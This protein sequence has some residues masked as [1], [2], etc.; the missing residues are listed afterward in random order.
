MIN[1]SDNEQLKGQL[2]HSLHFVICA[3]CIALSEQKQ[4][5]LVGLLDNLVE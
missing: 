1:I 3:T 2:I 4:G 5:I